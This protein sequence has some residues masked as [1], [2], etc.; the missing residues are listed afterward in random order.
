[1]SLPFTTPRQPAAD[2]RDNACVRCGK[3]HV[4]CLIAGRYHCKECAPQ[5]YW[6]KNRGAA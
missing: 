2:P 6:P 4:G 5:D 3:L 1:M